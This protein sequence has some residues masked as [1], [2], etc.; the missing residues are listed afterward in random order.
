MQRTPV[1]FLSSNE[2][3][4]KNV[5]R[6][7]MFSFCSASAKDDGYF[8]AIQLIE[9]TYKALNDTASNTENNSEYVSYFKTN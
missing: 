2:P 3:N 1:M 6:R 5:S 8:F 9:D 7:N 4:L